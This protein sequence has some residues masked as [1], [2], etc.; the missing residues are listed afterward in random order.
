MSK[1]RDLGNYGSAALRNAMT[2]LTD[3]TT[4]D[5]LMPRGAFGWGG[6]VPNFVGSIDQANIPSGFYLVAPANGGVK[7]PASGSAFGFL[8]VINL[9]D[10]NRQ[11]WYDTSENPCFTRQYNASLGTWTSWATYL[12]RGAFGVGS[13]GS[14]PVI[15]DFNSYQPSGFYS[16]GSDV[17]S[18]P[19]PEGWGSYVLCL[20]SGVADRA[21]YLVMRSGSA[22]IRAWLSKREAGTLTT[23][24]L[25][26][27]RNI[28]GT[29]SQS[30]GIPTGA[31]IER[32]SNANGQ[33]VRYADGTQIC[34]KRVN[35]SGVTINPANGANLST[36][37][38]LDVT[39]AAAFVGI[40]AITVGR[41]GLADS[42]NSPIY[43]A[44]ISE[45]SGLSLLNTG[46]K[47]VNVWPSWTT[48]GSSV[49][50]Q[51][52]YEMTHIGRW[53]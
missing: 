11:I 6:T 53:Y 25:Y 2:S 51:G 34:Y 23:T 1:N 38:A 18:R 43:T 42:G 50:T 28:L 21:A 7:P 17:V 39:S 5:A 14:A 48:A 10:R 3:V 8:Q 12:F 27:S 46:H 30:G 44:L 29:A 40:P 13:L 32:G 49:A 52:F 9:G 31:I 37:Q 47:P 41:F 35:F 24:E 45:L 33:Y 20:G 36:S 19:D 26:H 22:A 4:S 15:T 16:A